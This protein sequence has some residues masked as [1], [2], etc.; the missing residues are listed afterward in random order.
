MPHDYRNVSKDLTLPFYWRR[1]LGIEERRLPSQVSSE[2]S[3]FLFEVTADRG[4]VWAS[5]PKL[6]CG[7]TRLRQTDAS[8]P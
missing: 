4:S 7:Q 6:T 3:K 8:A 2:L 1:M 5:K